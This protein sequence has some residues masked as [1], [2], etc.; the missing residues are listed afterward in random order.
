[1]S[2]G[3]DLTMLDA[4]ALL[5]A[6]PATV[7]YKAVTEERPGDIDGVR[8]FIDA[9]KDHHSRLARGFLLGRAV[10]SISSDVHLMSAE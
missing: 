7:V 1:M 5:I 3:H 9:Y 8:E 6:V 2:K 4:V 10:S